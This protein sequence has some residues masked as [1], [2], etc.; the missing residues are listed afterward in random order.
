MKKL[1]FV[2]LAFASLCVTITI[3]APLCDQCRVV[4]PHDPDDLFYLETLGSGE[5]YNGPTDDDWCFSTTDCSD[6]GSY[7]EEEVH[8]T[9]KPGC[10]W[11]G[12]SEPEE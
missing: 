11:V 3:A 5:C 1:V 12:I 10:R 7:C 8:C 6:G 4:I 2:F 9:S